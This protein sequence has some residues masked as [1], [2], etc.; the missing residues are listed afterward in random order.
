MPTV[1]SG[2]AYVVQHNIDTDQI[3]P[4]QYLTLVPPHSR[5]YESSAA[6]R[7]IGLPGLALSEA[8]TSRKARSRPSTRSSSGGRNFRAAAPLASTPPSP[9]APPDAKSSS[10]KASPAFVFALHRHRRALTPYE[11]RPLRPGNKTGDQRGVDFDKEAPRQWQDLPLKP[12]GEVKP[13]VDAGGTSFCAPERTHPGGKR[14][15]L[16]IVKLRIFVEA[17]S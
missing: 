15:I 11:N 13:V 12:L 5:R 4:R 8:A 1:I 14:I 3:I 10:R 7:C 17:P 9:P 16:C 6:T 2:P